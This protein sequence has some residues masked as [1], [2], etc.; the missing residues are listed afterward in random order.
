M[1]AGAE[2]VG[3]LREPDVAVLGGVLAG[4]PRVVDGLASHADR[5]S[6]DPAERLGHDA[7]GT[8]E[9]PA[10][11]LG[12]GLQFAAAAQHV[13]GVVRKGTEV[14]LAR[15]AE[16]PGFDGHLRGGPTAQ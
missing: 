11:R 9:P 1:V 16:V 5:G 4:V 6:E 14:V 12:A 2:L 7:A 10:A 15:G 13:D 3:A 8:A